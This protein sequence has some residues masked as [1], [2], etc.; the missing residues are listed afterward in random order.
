MYVRVKS[1]VAETL[2]VALHSS[3]CGAVSCAKHD[4]DGKLSKC[5]I[6]SK[7]PLNDGV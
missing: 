3:P 5:K 6:W 4:T 7:A 2:Y 1:T